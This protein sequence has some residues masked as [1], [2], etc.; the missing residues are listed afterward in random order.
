MN[1][2]E[3]E[4]MKHA[5]GLDYRRPN[6]YRENRYYKPYR[7][8]FGAGENGSEV[9]EGLVEKGL[10]ET[11]DHRMYCVSNKGLEELSKTLH[12]HVYSEYSSCV[13]D[14]KYPVFK[15]IVN[16]F[17]DFFSY[18]VSS[19]FIAQVTRI[20]LKLVRETCSYLVEAGLIKKDHQ[21]GFDH[22]GLYCLH[23]YSLT[24]KAFEHPYYEEACKMH[25]EIIA[26]TMKGDNA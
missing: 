22:D 20:P 26:R 6:S 8:Y 1:N 14:A 7:N 3:L 9:W 18:P 11:K 2:K 16:Q 19:K 25:E 23:G 5:I 21:G 10:A 4:Y 15:V 17:T 24:E 13:G 12:V